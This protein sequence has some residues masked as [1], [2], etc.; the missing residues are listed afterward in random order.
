MPSVEKRVRDGRTTWLARYRE[1]DGTQR[2]KTFARRT[3]ADRFLDAVRGDLAHGTYVDPAGGRRAFG[4]YAAEWQAARVHRPTTAAQVETH[5]RRHILPFFAH[6]PLSAVRRSEIQGWV[7]GRAGVLEPAT[8]EV[9]YRYLASIFRAAVGD[10]LIASSPCQEIALPKRERRRLVPLETEQIRRLVD[11]MPDRY[12]GLVVTTAG[13]GLRQGEVFGL[14][15]DR[16]DF[17]GR[18]LEVAQQL[19]LVPGGPPHLAPPK[20]EASRRTVPLPQVVLNELA[21]HLATFPDGES[22]LIFT[23][24]RGEAIRRTAFGVPWRRA[25]AAADLPAGTGFHALRHYYASLLIRHGESVKVVQAR[26]GHASAAETLDTYSHLWPD[27]EDRTRAA[28]DAV[29]GAAGD[30]RDGAV[31]EAE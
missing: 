24:D 2:K 7:K 27:S 11:A 10:R 30:N 1:P 31:D 21:T 17:L 22:G 15:L 28:V 29:L 13:T 5:L 8:V 26:L 12:R 9:V 19:V 6:R 3:D 23:N 18:R 16:V 14:T 4:E 20:T 25:I